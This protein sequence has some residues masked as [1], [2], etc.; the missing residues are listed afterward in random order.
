MITINI[1]KLLPAIPVL[2]A[3]LFGCAEDNPT[4][5]S[6]KDYR[7][8]LKTGNT[9]TYTR[10]ISLN[11][12]LKTGTR[13]PE[14]TT[15][16]VTV[17]VIGE[18]TIFDSLATIK[19]REQIQEG[20]NTVTSHNFYESNGASLYLVATHNGPLVL[21][22]R[23][24]GDIRVFD[25]TFTSLFDVLAAAEGTIA[26][27]ANDSVHLENPAKV[28]LSYPLEAGKEWP[29][30][31]KNKPR[32]V[33]K[34]V[35]GETEAKTLAG[36]FQTV[37]L[38]WRMDFSGDGEIDNNVEFF[39]YYAEQGLVKRSMVIRNLPLVDN[40]GYNIGSYTFSDVSELIAY[41]VK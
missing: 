17:Q 29:Y 12:K 34:R 25:R 38:Q 4:G 37:K 35:A 5:P 41:T 36:T 13:A 8:P 33:S 6:S 19:V 3:L 11:Y 18:E 10:T 2:A 28:V 7:Y 21:P 9:W 15:A 32:L 40:Q 1:K 23:A 20:A 27:A 22:K 39:D 30:S 14:T 31:E 24:A 16:T 26:S